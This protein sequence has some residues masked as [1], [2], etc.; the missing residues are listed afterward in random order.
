MRGAILIG[1]LLAVA[2][3]AAAA[4]SHDDNTPRSDPIRVV[5]APAPQA[6]RPSA[7]AV[8]ATDAPVATPPASAMAARGTW[9]R[10]VISDTWQWQ[11]TGKINTNYDVSVYDI[12]LFEAPD[13]VLTQLHVQGRRVV[14]Y[15]S[16]GSSENWRPDFDQFQPADMGKPLDGWKGERWLDTRSANVRRIMMARLDLAA[17]RG[18]DGVEPDNVEAYSNGSGLPLTAAD[19]LDYNRFIANEAHRRGLAVGLKNDLPQIKALVDAFDFA[20]NE[21]CAQY[22]ECAKLRPFTQAGKPVFNA[23]YV[24][25]FRD[26]TDGARDAMCAAARMASI[27]SLVLPLKLNDAYRYSCD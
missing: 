16:A 11:L 26:N 10:P 13:A 7:V 4:V 3:V 19:Q 9:W 20:V 2:A 27:R 6:E 17:T 25:R 12:D 21:Q 5:A 18:C 14:C 23:E 15:F 24:A 8:S 22:K 1:G